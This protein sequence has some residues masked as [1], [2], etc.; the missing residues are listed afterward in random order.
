MHPWWTSLM[1]SVCVRC[2]PAF[3]SRAPC[4]LLSGTPLFAVLSSLSV[5]LVSITYTLLLEFGIMVDS[6]FF[7][8]LLEIFMSESSLCNC[9]YKFLV[10][11]TSVLHRLQ[12]VCAHSVQVLRLCSNLYLF[13][14]SLCLPFNWG[15]GWRWYVFRKKFDLRFIGKNMIWNMTICRCSYNA[16]AD[17]ISTDPQP[18]VCAGHRGYYACLRIYTRRTFRWHQQSS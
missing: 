1:I 9:F 4:C 6:L 17:G 8:C 7:F 3:C 12:E 2:F 5:L 16:G 13:A 14:G 10:L 15:K 18:L 11:D